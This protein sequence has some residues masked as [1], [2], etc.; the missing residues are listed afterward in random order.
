MIKQNTPYVWAS[1]SSCPKYCKVKQLEALQHARPWHDLHEMCC[2]LP[3]ASASY[4]RIPLVKSATLL[5]WFVPRENSFTEPNPLLF[6][7]VLCVSN[8]SLFCNVFFVSKV[9]D[10][11]GE[12][13]NLWNICV[14]T[15]QNIAW[16]NV[17]CFF[18][19][20]RCVR[21]FQKYWQPILFYFYFW[22]RNKTW[23]GLQIQIVCQ[24]NVFA[25]FQQCFGAL[26]RF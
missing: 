16:Q 26:F 17:F 14:A 6:K 23:L 20:I 3:V 11:L 1:C 19:R 22:S 7:F 15:S 24:A 12:I 9:L 4:Q 21:Y 10:F 18:T 5:T 2:T 8:F 13:F 25:S